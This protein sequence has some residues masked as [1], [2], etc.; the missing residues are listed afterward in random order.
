LIGGGDRTPG[1][2]AGGGHRRVWRLVGLVAAGLGVLG[3]IVVTIAYFTAERPP[4]ELVERAT[5]AVGKARRDRAEDYAPVPLQSAESA[6]YTAKL[7]WQMENTR[8][9][10]LRDFE[11]S[12]T[13]AI[14]ALRTAG[15]ASSRSLAVQDSLRSRATT[16]IAKSQELLASYE[17][18]FGDMP[19]RSSLRRRAA[20]GRVSLG[21]SQLALARGDLAEAAKLA[22]QAEAS[23]NG[24]AERA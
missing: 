19:L 1:R 3:A 22:A 6:L 8:W 7:T 23:I 13:H 20:E 11:A 10:P 24:A 15:Q 9:R 2:K 12:R 5:Q 4:L 16:S 18:E 14:D 17:A 21:R